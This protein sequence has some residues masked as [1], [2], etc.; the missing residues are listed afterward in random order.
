MVSNRASTP[1]LALSV[2]ALGLA[3]CQGSRLPYLGTR[4]GAPEPLAP[5]PAGTVAS[6]ELPPPGGTLDPTEFPEAP[7]GGTEG[8]VTMDVAAA[9]ATE[10][11]KNSVVGSWKAAA[12][13]VNC[14]MFL[15]LTKY[16]SNSRGGTRGCSGELTGM[17]G[18]NVSGKQLLIYDETGS[19]IAVLYSTGGERFDGQTAAGLA[20]SLS[21]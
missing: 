15:T 18:W 10:I 16:G 20:V 21:R 3:G 5:A 9:N 8:A 12:A 11:N 4:A 13:G 1:V 14:Q 2:L 19:Q 17:R 7:G 6:S